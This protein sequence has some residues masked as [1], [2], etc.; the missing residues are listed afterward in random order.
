MDNTM[1]PE[2]REIGECVCGENQGPQIRLFWSGVFLLPG[3]YCSPVLK[4]YVMDK[5]ELAYAKQ[6]VLVVKDWDAFQAV[7]RSLARI[8]SSLAEISR[9]VEIKKT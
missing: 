9:P 2:E 1:L 8:L 6:T 3:R 4:E 5:K 7:I